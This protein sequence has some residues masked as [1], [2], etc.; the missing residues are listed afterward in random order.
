MSVPVCPGHAVRMVK[1]T[2]YFCATCFLSTH[3]LGPELSPAAFVG[4]GT[5]ACPSEH[6]LQDGTR[7]EAL[8]VSHPGLQVSDGIRGAV[9]YRDLVGICSPLDPLHRPPE[10][11]TT[12][13][14]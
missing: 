11:T 12:C 2:D 10:C 1:G 7:K 8:A 6:P 5:R 9:I 13:R 14:C 3:K 4:H